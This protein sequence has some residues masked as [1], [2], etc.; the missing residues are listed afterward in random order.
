MAAPTSTEPPRIVFVLGAGAS[1]ELGL[2]VGAELKTKIA[3]QAP[4][5][6]AHDSGVP[7]SD[8]SGDR[9]RAWTNGDEDFFDLRC[10]PDI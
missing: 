8:P 3:G 4:G 7:F 2:P 10:C 6:K 5:R 9:L 1:A